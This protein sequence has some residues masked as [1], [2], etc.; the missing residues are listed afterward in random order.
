MTG[1]RTAEGLG[2]LARDE[3]HETGDLGYVD[4][5]GRL[6]LTGRSADVIKSGGY[7]VAP[8]EVERLLAP[9]LQPSEIAVLGI[10]SDY[11]GEVILA[12]VEN[13]APGWEERIDRVMRTMTDYKRPRLLIALDELPR[14]GIGK[15]LRSAIRTEVLSRFRVTEGSR[16]RL[17]RRD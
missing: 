16:P 3:F 2:L 10:P 1:Y 15:I 8:E 9:A 5:S 14:N 11:W 4:A 6:H 17:E 12:A 7:K 13:P